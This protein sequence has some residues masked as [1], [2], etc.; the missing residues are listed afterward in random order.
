[1]QAPG[2]GSEAAERRLLP[3]AR[4]LA[5]D[6]FAAEVGEAFE[7]AGVRYVLL[8]GPTVAQW[9]Y[10]PD[11]VRG[12]LDVDVLGHPA[13]LDRARGVLATKGLELSFLE[14]ALPHG[15]RPHAEA[16]V[17]PQSGLSVDL[18]ET[19]PG[20][21]V[22]PSAAWLILT[23][24]KDLIEV[25]GLP[26]TQL[27]E[28]ART[29]VVALHAAHHGV[30]DEQALADLARALDRVERPT[31]RLAADLADRLRA[32]AAFAAGL[33]LLASGR[34]LAD[35]LELPTTRSIETILR[36]GSA[37]ELSLSLDWLVQTRGFRPR[38]VL[39]LRKLAPPHEVLMAR[40]RLA[41]RGR[42]GLALAYAIQPLHL[43]VRADRRFACGSLHVDRSNDRER[44]ARLSLRDALPV[45]RRR[46]ARSRREALVPR[47]GCR[48][49]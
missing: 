12:Y 4:T 18:H 31:W 20:V 34:E 7:A 42:W 8:K 36:A 21:A 3:T 26:L 46:S 22:D 6:S 33:R 23:E 38:A 25:A 5:L 40:S 13:D 9:L 27:A 15:R 10:R 29:L 1:M 30:D 28:P 14:A 37:P 45:R 44:V 43:A 2:D 35:A 48:L 41:Q 11:E 39:I 24:R 47:L 32:A 19:L 17:N 49:R 16:W